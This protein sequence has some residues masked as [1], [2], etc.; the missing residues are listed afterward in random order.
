MASFAAARSI[1]R[2]SAARNAAARF[3][4]Q[5]KSKPKAS[6]FGLNST[7]SKPILRSPL[8]LLLCACVLIYFDL[9]RSKL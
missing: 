1:I 6:P 5:S 2:S 4:S 3:A 9:E 8:P 7:T